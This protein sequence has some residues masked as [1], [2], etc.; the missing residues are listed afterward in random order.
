MVYPTCL[1]VAMAI[2]ALP[3]W[4]QPNL[5]MQASFWACASAVCSCAL[6]GQPVAQAGQGTIILVFL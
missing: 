2:S 4:H 6:L 5:E 3:T 1:A